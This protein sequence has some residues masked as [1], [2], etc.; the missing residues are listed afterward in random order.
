MIQEALQSGK[1][2]LLAQW[3][4][5]GAEFEWE[6]IGNKKLNRVP[7]PTYPFAKESYWFTPKRTKARLIVKVFTH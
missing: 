1:E 6:T 3:W 4:A 2:E 5:N 7:M